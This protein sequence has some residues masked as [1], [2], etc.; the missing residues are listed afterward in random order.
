MR[1]VFYSSDSGET[2]DRLL[3]LLEDAA[4]P[5]R[6]D[7]FDGL[8]LLARFLGRLDIGQAVAVVVASDSKELSELISMRD[9]FSQ[10]RLVLLV[11]DR[12]N[13]TVSKGHLMRPRFLSYYDGD[14]SDVAAVLG[15]MI[16][17][18]EDWND[19]PAKSKARVQ[20]GR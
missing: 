20:D 6:L 19:S 16:A 5:I 18:S 2:R 14:F 3:R 12:T 9:W 10:L 15:K 13:E 4:A 1:V 17:N 11:P 8:G 7:K